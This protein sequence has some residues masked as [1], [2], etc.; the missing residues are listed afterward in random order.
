MVVK[1]V[2]AVRCSGRG[3][4][5]AWGHGGERAAV[6]RVS[7]LRQRGGVQVSIGEDR[8]T[9]SGRLSLRGPREAAAAHARPPTPEGRRA[10][11]APAAGDAG[12]QRSGAGGRGLGLGRSETI[13]ATLMLIRT[14]A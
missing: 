4:G 11:P 5:R 2:L 6:K 10:T 7:R 12:A 3:L 13:K 9:K 14:P 1:I 8:D